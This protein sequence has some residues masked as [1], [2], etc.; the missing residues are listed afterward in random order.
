MRFCF[1]IPCSSVDV[2]EIGFKVALFWGMLAV[3]A[4]EWNYEHGHYHGGGIWPFG[5]AL[6]TDGYRNRCCSSRALGA[7][8]Q[9][10][11]LER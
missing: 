7:K 3:L 2:L 9:Q 4:A 11:R 6:G 5:V 1:A 8:R 10:V